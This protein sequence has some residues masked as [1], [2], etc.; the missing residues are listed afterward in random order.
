MI[1]DNFS[2]ELKNFVRNVDNVLAGICNSG[3][4]LPPSN[5]A[6]AVHSFGNRET[7]L[8]ESAE[9][10]F[11]KRFAKRLWLEMLAG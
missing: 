5:K 7:A 9:R 6:N 1:F 11:L 3:I 8:F 2:W 10:S 4:I